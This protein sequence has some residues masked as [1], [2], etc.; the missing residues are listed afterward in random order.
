MTA[1]GDRP[2]ARP[3]AALLVVLAAGVCAC[4]SRALR[5][6]LAPAEAAAR[7]IVAPVTSTWLIAR[8]T[9]PGAPMMLRARKVGDT[10]ALADRFPVLVVLT[11]RLRGVRPEGLPSNPEYDVIEGFEKKLDELER[12]GLGLLVAV[13]TQSGEAKYFVYVADVDAVVEYMNAGLREIDDVRYS[14]D[15]NDRWREYEKI[16]GVLHEPAVGG[17]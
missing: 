9:A 13:R 17:P 7:S 16:V 5:R 11:R 12:R 14:S 2:L 3:L 6:A 10:R 8:G 4:R 1:L 15:E